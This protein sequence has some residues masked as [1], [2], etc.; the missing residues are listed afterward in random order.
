MSPSYTPKGTLDDVFQLGVLEV[1]L[2]VSLNLSA[3]NDH[4]VKEKLCGGHLIISVNS[5]DKQMSMQTLDGSVTKP[6]R[7][8]VIDSELQ[9][10]N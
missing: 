10:G 7:T 5:R 9:M 8:V 4:L 6:L 1:H 3:L 2:K